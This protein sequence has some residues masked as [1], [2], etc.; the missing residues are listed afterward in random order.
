MADNQAILINNLGGSAGF[1]EQFL[2]RNDDG[3]TSLVDITSIFEGGLNFFG[4]EFTGLWVNNNGSVTF[5]GPRSA[6]TPTV[7]TGNNANPEITPFFA[8]VDTRGGAVAATPGGNST[9]T[10]LVHYD[11]DTVND[12]FIVTWDDVGYFSSRTDKLNSF[13]LILSDRGGGDFDIQF[14]YETINWTTGNASGGSGGLGGTPARAGF[15]ASTGNPDAFFELPASG[16]QDG[17]LQLDEVAGNTGEIGIWNFS[18]RS[19]EIDSGD[20]PALPAIPVIGTTTGDP[21]LVTLDGIAY[22]FH[23]AGEFVLMRATDGADFE[24]QSRMTPVPGSDALTVN[25]AIAAR[26]GGQNVMID[27]ND[28]NPFS[29]DGLAVDITNFSF[30]QVGN[31]RVFR[32]NNVYTIVFAGGDNVVGDGD[33]RLRITVLDDRVDF[34]ATLNSEFAGRL[35][36]LLGNADG[37][38]ANDVAFANGTP[39]LRPFAF[40]DVYGRYRSDWRVDT[41]SESLFTYDSGES[42]EGFYLPEHPGRIITL[43]DFPPENVEAARALLLAAGLVEG[44]TNFNNALIDYLATG[45]ASYIDSADRAPDIALSE[46]TQVFTADELNRPTTG[47]DQLEGTSAP[48][49][50]DALAGN[51]RVTGGGGNDTLIGSAGNDTLLGG[52]GGDSMRGGIGNDSLNGG[53]GNDRLFGQGGNDSLVGFGGNDTLDGGNGADLLLGQRGNDSLSGGGSSDTLDGGIGN[54]I[55]RGGT[56]GDDFVFMHRGGLDR[57]VD[58]S[59][60]RGDMLVLDDALWTGTLTEQQIVDLFADVRNRSVVFEFNASTQLTLVGI[61]DTT[62]LANAIDIL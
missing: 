30:I 10:N 23:A 26:V 36:G 24:V 56:G 9:G 25:Q 13:Q 4:R 32:S 17:I 41:V 3:S 54:D 2:D 11:F 35:E 42:L 55:L 31:D 40:E 19:G 8:D 59:L 16:N 22:D 34:V 7:I 49:R 48:E 47:D 33:A 14:R 61:T 12:R 18:V 58:F 44:T 46:D 50:I 5:N 43:E 6:F 51:D 27:A 39:L 37:N 28:A 1:G 57:I 29:V 45:D 21:R 20:I 52:G 15:T 53:T 60:N 38:P 62:R